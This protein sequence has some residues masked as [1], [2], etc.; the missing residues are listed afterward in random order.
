M[1][2]KAYKSITL[3]GHIVIFSRLAVPQLSCQR[4]SSKKFII[5]ERSTWTKVVHAAPLPTQQVLPKGSHVRAR[6]T[7]E[8][9]L[10][11]RGFERWIPE[12]LTPYSI[13]H[14][15]FFIV[16]LIMIYYFLNFSLKFAHFNPCSF[17][18]LCVFV[19]RLLS[20]PPLFLGYSIARIYPV[21]WSM[22]MR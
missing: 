7:P 6:A 4:A 21:T 14:C 1:H 12:D 19:S 17:L 2:T 13:M 9:L 18:P 10:L 20:L 8:G 16:F 15:G 11:F 22:S 5:T 3:G